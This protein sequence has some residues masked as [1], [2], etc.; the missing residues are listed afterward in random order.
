MV[1]KISCQNYY[2]PKGGP[3]NL[4]LGLNKER[5]K[6]ETKLKQKI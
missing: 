6:T 4:F 3:R 5:D 2:L 1:G